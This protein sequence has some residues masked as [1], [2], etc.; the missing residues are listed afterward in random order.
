MEKE[1]EMVKSNESANST[2]VTAESSVTNLQKDN[3]DTSIGACSS[4]QQQTIVT[5]ESQVT[6]LQEDNADTSI[7]A[8]SSDQ[9][10]KNIHL[11][12]ASFKLI[13]R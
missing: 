2:A 3:A 7:G 8:Y 11:R 5:S 12:F 13:G 1:T 6:R 4:D 10:Q 9:H